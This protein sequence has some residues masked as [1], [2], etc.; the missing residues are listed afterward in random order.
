MEGRGAAADRDRRG[1]FNGGPGNCPAKHTAATAPATASHALQWR[2]GQLPGQTPQAGRRCPSRQQGLQWRA[3]QLPGQTRRYSRMDRSP[4]TRLQWRAG[5]LPGQTTHALCECCAALKPSMEGRA[6]ARPNTSH[7]PRTPSPPHT[8]N[9][10][11]G[12]CPAKRHRR[13]RA[14]H[15]AAGPSMEGRAIARPNR[16]PRPPT[17]RVSRI[18]QWRAGQLPGQ[19]RAPRGREAAQDDPSMEGRA[20]ARPNPRSGALARPG[21]RAF[22][23]GPGNC[24]AKPMSR[25]S[26]TGLSPSLQWRAGQLPGQTSRRR[27]S[28]TGRCAF[29]G[30]PGNCPAK[31]PSPV[32]QLVLD[33][34][35]SMEGRAIARPNTSPSCA[36]PTAA[37]SLQWRAGQLPGQTQVWGCGQGPVGLPSM[38]GRAIARPNGPATASCR[39]GPASFNGGP[40]NCPA[41]PSSGIPEMA[42]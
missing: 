16:S 19:T 3:G 24:P 30:G 27:S 28:R 7:P 23:G 9:G 36:A 35:P 15:L 29:N 18:L 31:H 5:Q 40:G 12:N 10:G 34:V 13:S 33:L 4:R 11:P 21:R 22:N 20:I 6:I 14:A 26:R 32:G 39:R 25:P 38:E 41:K 8:F 1:S 17:V 2:A 42:A 37:T